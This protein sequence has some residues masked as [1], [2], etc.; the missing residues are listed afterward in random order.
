[1]SDGSGGGNKTVFRPSPLQGLRQ[2]G[3]GQPP[4]QPPVGQPYP[5]PPPPAGGNGGFGAPLPLS[6]PGQGSQGHGLA[7]SRLAEDDV[8]L[9]ATPRQ[10]RNIMLAEAEPVLALV[11]SVRSGRR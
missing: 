2:G 10:V 7:P 5:P 6:H 1:M 3:N 9:P 8:P 4:Q 11:A